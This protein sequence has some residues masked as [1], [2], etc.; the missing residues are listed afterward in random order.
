MKRTNKGAQLP[1]GNHTPAETVEKRPSAKG[2][3]CHS[4]GTGTQC[5]ESTMSGLARIREVT[6]WD[7]NG[8]YKEKPLI[9]KSVLLRSTQ[10]RSRMR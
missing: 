1:E 9:P 7:D 2:N 8:W 3:H 5:P 4:T 10:G 6:S